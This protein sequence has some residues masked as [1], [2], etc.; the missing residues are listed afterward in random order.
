MDIE[1]VPNNYNRRKTDFIQPVSHN[2]DRRSVT[3]RATEH[4]DENVFKNNNLKYKNSK[5]TFKKGN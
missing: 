1:E 4:Q 5:E 3:P 2:R